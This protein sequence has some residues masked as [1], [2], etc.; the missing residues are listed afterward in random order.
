MD[1]CHFIGSQVELS[2]FIFTLQSVVTITHAMLLKTARHNLY[3]F[4]NSYLEPDYEGKKHS[5]TVVD[6]VPTLTVHS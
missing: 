4:I 1:H 6:H 2:L 5:H 3:K